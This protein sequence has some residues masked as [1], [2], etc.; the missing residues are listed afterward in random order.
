M[1]FRTQ[2]KEINVCT[3]IIY[4]V[5]FIEDNANELLSSLQNKFL[6]FTRSFDQIKDYCKSITYL[7]QKE[8]NK[9]KNEMYFEIKLVN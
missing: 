5:P 1:T 4:K 8:Y 2:L 9:K 7:G 6:E 3:L